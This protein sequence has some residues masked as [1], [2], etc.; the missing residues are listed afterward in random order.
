MPQACGGVDPHL[1]VFVQSHLRTAPQP[2]RNQATVVAAQQKW[3]YHL[4]RA[5]FQSAKF[6]FRLPG[7]HN[8][9]DA[10]LTY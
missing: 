4:L 9:S 10:V 1:A 5:P 2:H 7:V 3:Q 8:F 6:L